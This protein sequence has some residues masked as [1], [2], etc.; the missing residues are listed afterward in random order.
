VGYINK[1][2]NLVMG[3]GGV[4]GI[5]YIG[6]FEVAEK[7]GYRLENISGVSAGSLAGAFAAAGYK[8]GEIWKAMQS[9][10]FDGVQMSKASTKV[11]V[12]K[13]FIDFTSGMRFE[14]KRSIEEFLN[15]EINGI[16]VTKDEQDIGLSDYRCNLNILKSIITY[17]KEG[18]LFDGDYFE[19]WLCKVLAAKGVRTFADLRGGIVD[20][21]NPRGYKVRMTGVDCNRAKVVVLPD[22][23]EFYGI[24]PDNFE[25][26]KAV[27]ISC[28]VPFAFKPVEIRKKVEN[29]VRTYNLVDGGVLD[30]FPSWLIAPSFIH[31]LGLMLN[32][33]EKN[34][35]F[36]IDTPLNIMKSLISAVHDIGVPEHAE[37][38]VKFIGEINTTKVSF[39]NFSLSDDDKTYLFNSGRQAAIL[40][41]NNFERRTL[42]LSRRLPAFFAPL[43]KRRRL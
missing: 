16:E 19:E 37:N 32:G 22:D 8:S 30:S 25:V 36:S 21:V 24:E 20:A 33:G 23:M 18:C 9:F 43:F 38:D 34:K 29:K 39:L 12:V 6:S 7:R 14:G 10:D 42:A 31:T 17:S 11:P 27:R 2:V 1:A 3:G 28:C 15:Q 5:A 41:F 4:K 40:L 13:R 35:F 26:A